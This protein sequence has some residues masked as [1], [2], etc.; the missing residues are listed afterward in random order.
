MRL[1][2]ADE[3]LELI[4]L[5]KNELERLKADKLVKCGVEQIER[6]IKDED[7][8]PTVLT[9]PNNPTNGDMIKAMFHITDNDIDEDLTT[10]YVYAKT[11]VLKGGSQD[12]LRKQITFRKDWWNTPHKKEVEE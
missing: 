5:Y 10:I 9:I 4:K 8:I 2:I 6:F 11:R 3:V 1:I 7:I 12:Y